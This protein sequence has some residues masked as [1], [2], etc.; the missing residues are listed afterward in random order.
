M[1]NCINVINDLLNKAKSSLEQKSYSTSTSYLKQCEYLLQTTK[2]HPSSKSDFLFQLA[3]QYQCLNQKKSTISILNSILKL[4]P[5]P[6]SQAKAHLNLAAVF[7]LQGLYEKSIFHNSK[8]LFL[9]YET[10][11]YEGQVSAYLGLAICYQRLRQ[12]A[13]SITSSKQGL[14]ISQKHLGQVHKLTQVLRELYYGSYKDMKL[15]GCKN[16]LLARCEEL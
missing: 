2:L 3:N 9:L 13:K 8:A 12:V 10:Q 5:E 14:L 7:S 11:E 15:L 1:E 16:S 4:T 6:K